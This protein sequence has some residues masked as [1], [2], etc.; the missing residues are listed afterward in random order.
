MEKV[1]YRREKQLAYNAA[2]GITP[3]SV[4]RAVEESLS[5]QKEERSLAEAVLNEGS[6]N[7][8]VTETIRELEAQMIEAS[9]NL[10][11]EKA[12]LCRDQINELKRMVSGEPPAKAFAYGKP[13]KTKARKDGQPKFMPRL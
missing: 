10:E 1:S 4:S 9:N 7:F 8:D 12:A 3:R 2:H 5:A 6:G 11:F 13:R